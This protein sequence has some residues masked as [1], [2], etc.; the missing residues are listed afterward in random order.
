MKDIIIGC[1]AFLVSLVRTFR[2]EDLNVLTWT[3]AVTAV[4]KICTGIVVPF[5]ALAVAVYQFRIQRLRHKREL[6]EL[7]KLEK[8]KTNG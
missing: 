7:K 6:L 3:A 8:G 5:I 4:A 2:P 1:K